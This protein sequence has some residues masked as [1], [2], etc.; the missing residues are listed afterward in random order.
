M[1]LIVA[2]WLWLPVAISRTPGDAV[3]VEFQAVLL[4]QREGEY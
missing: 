4:G 3:A 1:P 2:P